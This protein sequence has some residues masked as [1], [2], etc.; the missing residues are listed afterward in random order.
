MQTKTAG[1]AVVC[2]AVLWI[3]G[4]GSE[5]AETV[6]QTANQVQQSVTKSVESAQ[7]TVQEK[8]EMA[9][10]SEVT[11][12][13]S[14]PGAPT[15]VAPVKTAGCYALFTPATGGRPSVL[16]LQSYKDASSE[17]FPSLCIQAQVT[18]DSLSALAG[19]TVPATM[20][21]KTAAAGPTWYTP[22]G[23]TVQLKIVSVAGQQVTAEVMSG[24]LSRSDGGATQPALGKFT[25]IVP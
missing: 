18:G 5:L 9:G 4:C 1:A 14:T 21:V 7:T 22:T 17:A 6:Q 2:V 15:A 16:A 13:A 23:E 12:D 10:S 11:L 3:V 25:A 24:T 20:F 8:L 19:Q